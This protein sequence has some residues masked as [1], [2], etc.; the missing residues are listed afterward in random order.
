[1]SRAGMR[2]P[3]LVGCQAGE[4]DEPGGLI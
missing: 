4:L 2:R 3:H 1:L